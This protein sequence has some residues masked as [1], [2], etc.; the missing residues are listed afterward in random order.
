MSSNWHSSVLVEIKTGEG[1]WIPCLSVQRGVGDA[2]ARSASR[3]PC[4]AFSERSDCG[5]APRVLSVG[6]GHGCSQ[7]GWGDPPRQPLATQSPDLYQDKP[8]EALKVAS[9]ATFCS[10]RA[11]ENWASLGYSVRL[12]FTN[13]EENDVHASCRFCALD[14]FSKAEDH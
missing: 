9:V 7:P 1:E 13:K 11:D 10:P 12:Y 6:C 8:C 3:L 5:T 4:K 14:P 2:S